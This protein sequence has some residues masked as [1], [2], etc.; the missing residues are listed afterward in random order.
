[1]SYGVEWALYAVNPM[2]QAVAMIFLITAAILAAVLAGV[3]PGVSALTLWA[4]VLALVLAVSPFTLRMVRKPM[5][6]LKMSEIKVS[7][8]LDINSYKRM[9][10]GAKIT[11]LVITVFTVAILGWFVWD[12]RFLFINQ[13]YW[14]L[15]LIGVLVLQAITFA[16]FSCH[17]G[18]LAAKKELFNYLAS[19]ANIDQMLNRM[20]IK[21]ESSQEVI[22]ELK[23]TYLNV[24]RFNVGVEDRFLVDNFYLLVLNKGLLREQQRNVISAESQAKT[25]DTVAK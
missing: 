22:D 11:S 5:S 12:A 13:D 18:A 14:L 15:K 1:M 21:D 2:T 7:P 4:L 20:L 17:F 10:K 23:K 6:K 24:G 3:V 8:N 9:A 19:L 16:F 25:E